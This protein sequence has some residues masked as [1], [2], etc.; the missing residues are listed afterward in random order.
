MKIK[1]VVSVGIFASVVLCCNATLY[2]FD[3]ASR[4]P[5]QIQVP[6]TPEN[7]GVFLGGHDTIT[8]EAMLLKKRAHSGDERF[9]TWADRESLPF[10]RVGAHDEDT[11]AVFNRWLNDPPL[12][13]YGWGNF[14]NH[15]YNPY[16]DENVEFNSLG[17]PATKAAQDYLDQIN[18]FTSCTPGGFEGLS[19]ADKN[20]LYHYLGRIMHLYQDM[21]CPSHTKSDIHVVK[22]P[23]ETY[24]D[25]NWGEITSSQA[26]RDRVSISNYFAGAYE[27]GA[28]IN[29]IEAMKQAAKTTSSYPAEEELYEW[30]LCSD[31]VSPCQV[32]NEERLRR[33]VE[34]LVPAA[35]LHSAGYIDSIYR[36]VRGMSS[37]DM[38]VPFLLHGPGGDHPDDR[39]DVSDAFY[40]EANLNLSDAA[41]TDLLLRT[42]MKKGNTSVWHRKQLVEM[43]GQGRA[44]PEDTPEGAKDALEKEFQRVLSRLKER[45][46]GK[47]WLT[48]PDVA[49]FAYGFYNPAISL[50]LKIKEPVRFLDLDFDPSIIR[51]HPVMLVPTAGFAGFEQSVSLKAKLEEYVRSGGTIIAFAQ[52]LGHHWNILP[53]P[54]NP[55]TG[56]TLPISGYGYQQDQNCQQNSVFIETYHPALSSFTSATIDVGVDGYFSSYPDNS[57]VLLRRTANGQPAMILYPYGNGYVVATTL[58]SDFAF[59]HNQANR[60]EINLIGNLISWAKKPSVL[61]QI[62][63]GETIALNIPV[64]NHMDGVAVSTKMEIYPP[65]RSALYAEQIIAG[66]V[67]S[68]ESTVIGTQ[69]AL[70]LN[71]ALGVYQVDYVLLDAQG[72]II[73]PSTEADSGRFILANPPKTG[74]PDKPIWFTITT[75]SQNVPFGEVFDY[76]FHVYNNSDVARNLVIKSIFGHTER[77]HTWNVSVQPRSKATVSG[78]DR[79]EDMAYMY[80]TMRAFLFDE[81]NREIGRYE[82]SFK[83]FFPFAT[84]AASSNKPVYSNNDDVFLK[85][86]ATSGQPGTY[87]IKTMILSPDNSLT[88]EDDRAVNIVPGTGVILDLQ[89]HLAANSNPGMYLV[90]SEIWQ[91]SRLL[92]S[93]VASFELP[94]SQIVVT[95]QEPLSFKAGNNTLNFG[96]RN[97]GRINIRSGTVDIQFLDPYGRTLYSGSHPFALMAGEASTLTVPIII[98]NLYFGD[99]MISYTQSDETKTGN[100]VSI[101]IPNSAEVGLLLDK[102]SYRI[103]YTANVCASI[104]NTGKFDLDNILATLDNYVIGF[105]NTKVFSLAR[106]QSVVIDFVMPIPETAPAG[107]HSTEFNLVIPSGGS[108]GQS[109]S[110]SIPGSSLA[111]HYNSSNAL[112]QGDS[113]PLSIE[114]TGGVDTTYRTERLSLTDNNGVT[115][116]SGTTN[117]TVRSGETKSFYEFQIPSQVP[118]GDAMLHVDVKDINTGKTFTFLRSLSLNGLEARIET[119]TDKDLYRKG[120][121]VT[122]ITN[123]INIGSLIENVNLDLSVYR[124]RAGVD[125]QFSHFLPRGWLPLSN[126]TG[127]ASDSEG[128]LYVVDPTEQLLI[129]INKN[130]GFINEFD[131][132]KSCSGGANDLCVPRGVAVG[133]DGSVY[134]IESG[135]TIYTSH[136]RVHKFDHDG[137]HRGTWGGYGLSE[138]NGLNRPSAIA[139]DRD[140]YVYIADTDNHRIVKYDSQG[141]FI[142]AWGN[143]GNSP[144]QFICPQGI[145]ADENGNIYVT[146]TEDPGYPSSG[147]HRVQKFDTSGRFIRQWGGY[148]AGNGLFIAPSGIAVGRDG[149]VYVGDTYSHTDNGHRIQKFDSSGVFIKAWGGQGRVEGTFE[150]PTGLLTD[151]DG[152]V[153]VADRGNSRIQKFNAEGDFVALWGGGGSTNGFFKGLRGLGVDVQGNIYVA[154]YYNERIQ[155]FDRNGNY[156]KQWGSEGIG[157]GQ[158]RSGPESVAVS[159]DG[160]VYAVNG[161]NSDVRIQK[162]D[163]EGNFLISWGSA[164]TGDGQFTGLQRIAV[165]A[166]GF[167]Y[168][169]DTGTKRVQKFGSDGSFITKWGGPGDGPGQFTE[170]LGIAISLD[171]SVY[172]A[173]PHRIQKF[174]EDGSFI[175]Q[176]GTQGSEAG[177]FDSIKA[178]MVDSKGFVYVIDS[179]PVRLQKFDSS[180]NFIT[181]WDDEGGG[182]MDSFHSPAGMVIDTEGFILISDKHTNRI[183]KLTP[184][185]T[186]EIFRRSSVISQPGNTNQQYLADLGA[187]SVSGKLYCEATLKNGIGQTLSKSLHPFYVASA[188][189]ALTM[190]VDKRIYKPGESITISGEVA[191]ISDSLLSGY[192]L[193]LILYSAS[194]GDEIFRNDFELSS[195]G[196][197]PFSFSFKASQEGAY[198][199]TAI[200]HNNSVKVVDVTEHFEVWAPK[201]ATEIACPSVVDDQPF[202]ID[203]IMQNTG[204]IEVAVDLTSSIDE[205]TFSMRIP[206]GTKRIV[207]FPQQINQDTAYRFTL[208]GDVNETHETWIYQGLIPSLYTYAYSMYQEGT[209]VLPIAIENSGLLDGKLIVS[210]EL[211]PSG[212]SFRK[213]YFIPQWGF[214]TDTLLFDLTEGDYTLTLSSSAPPASTSAS[215]SVRK[216]DAVTMSPLVISGPAGGIISVSSEVSNSGYRNTEGTAQLLLVN[217]QDV[218][219]WQSSQAINLPASAMATPVPVMFS[220]SPDAIQPGS[221]S[222]RMSFL[223]GGQ[224]ELAF[225]TVPLL[226]TGANLRLGRIPSYQTVSAGEEVTFSFGLTNLGGKT[227][228]AELTLKSHDFMNLTR[229]EMINPGEERNIQFAFPVPVDLEERDYYAEY[230]LKGENGII[231]KGQFRYHVTGINISV[232]A[233]L[234]KDHYREGETARLNMIINHQGGGGSKN[235]FARVNYPGYDD[236][237]PFSLGSSQNLSFDIPLAAISGEKL[238]Y[239]IYDE[240]G[241]SIHLNSLYIYK[242]GDSFSITTDKQVYGQ[243]EIV[244]MAIA[245]SGAGTMTVSGPG[246]YSETFLFNGSASKS[247]ALPQQAVAGTYFIEAS[248]IMAEGL[249][250]GLSKPIDIAGISVKVKEATLDKGKYLPG[251]NLRLSMRIE[252]NV[253]MPTTLKVW[254]VDPGK[255]TTLLGERPLSLSRV[256]QVQVSNEYQAAIASSGIHK[257]IYGI[258]SGYLLLSSGNL[259]FDAGDGVILDIATDRSDYPL[260]SEPV[261]VRINLYGTAA[262]AALVLNVN[263]VLAHT[264]AISFKGFTTTTIELPILGPGVHTLEGILTAGGLSS[265]KKTQLFYGSNL[266]DLSADVWGSGTTIAKDGTL[267]LLSVARN[268]GG[269]PASPTSMTLHD[270]NELLTA[271]TVRGLAPGAS[272]FFEFFWSVLG[273]AGERILVATLDPGNSTTEFIKDNNGVSRRIVIPDIALITE[274]D[275]DIYRA[276]EQVIVNATAI[277]L[278]VATNYSNLTCTTVIRDPSGTEI[279][280]HGRV[281]GASPSQIVLISATWNTAGLLTEGRYVIRQEI[282]SGSTLLAER[283]KNVTITAGSGLNLRAEPSSLRVKQGETGAF[284]ITVDAFA[285]WN[286]TIIF[287]VDGAPLGTTT[288]FLP[289]TM[290]SPGT[291]VLSITTD[292]A[293]V[294]G[295]Y[296]IVISAQSNDVP[297]MIVQTIPIT[298]EVSGFRLQAVPESISIAQQE[299]AEF[300]VSPLSLNGYEGSLILSDVSGTQAGLAVTV[301][302]T[303]LAVP[304]GETVVRVQSSKNALPG[305]YEINISGSDGV[306]SRNINL[307]LLVTENAAIQPGFV[308]TPGPGYDNRALVTLMNRNFEEKVEFIAFNTR[309][310]ANAVM[311]DIDGDGDDEII[312]APGPDPLADGRIRVFRKNGA[313]F[314]EQSIF[315]TKFGATLAAGDIDSD[316]REEIVVGAGPGLKNTSRLK[317]LSFDGQRFADTG[318]DFVAFPSTYKLGV[319]ITL[320]DVDGDGVLEIIAG[321]GPSPL[322]PPRIRVF[323]INTEGG[324]GRW[325]I[326]STLSDFVV[327]FGDWYPYLFGVNVAAGDVDGDGEDE[328]IA[329]AGPNPLQ[330]A[331]VAVYKGSGTF[332]GTRFEAYPANDYRFGVNVAARDLDGDG[333]AEIITGL[334]PS[335]FHESWVRVFRGDGT[336]LSDGFLAFPESMKSGVKVST[337]NVGE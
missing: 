139:V 119:R 262:E 87:N 261:A 302:N 115:I 7:A 326:A 85:V 228:F 46:F 179:N 254:S 67:P 107:L 331:V 68:H 44:L 242:T 264:E 140:G 269:T 311:G 290:S 232:V 245:G 183:R 195:S 92:S 218:V 304:G 280:R 53:T 312:V 301:V 97:N 123:I 332:T 237:R 336:L 189:I 109:T 294:P 31:N 94:R 235:L 126:P 165:N 161:A 60:S 206:P 188:N 201:L 66:Q 137:N 64:S 198:A 105:N 321:A 271:F 168:V 244:N 29:P 26:F 159:T 227:A 40:W 83:G 217:S 142:L 306:I 208:A 90:R 138:S 148:G 98:P 282:S 58:Y 257:I 178:I 223:D 158:F 214:T 121:T 277:N 247:F 57:I 19:Q 49:L 134:V 291:S 136:N 231:G 149:Y 295:T 203:V 297:A 240:E 327:N 225:Q 316:W 102:S 273:K 151:A 213:V 72:N 162:F 10:L 172:V 127:I 22:R 166:G 103:R 118:S 152:M 286:G 180:G 215:F 13:E 267:K 220:F 276:G 176:W 84:I 255:N 82:L 196:S 265:K 147:S 210:G 209:V 211:Q 230:E 3:N 243:G 73:Q 226:I 319:K 34:D 45:S 24:V 224:K 143:K 288:R 144:G 96:L 253:D 52:Q 130:G 76:T 4:N 251:D 8:S 171:G 174:N 205:R 157:D 248:L 62:R 81:S 78:S 324:I 252:S 191:N 310:G 289:E 20:R 292:G 5:A 86:M 16:T 181:Q 194:G 35:I 256:E 128:F 177:Q 234:D 202:S 6:Y 37:M 204:K 212:Y 17:R 175:T 125:S 334:G 173:E 216:K 275:K 32:L 308:L 88:F 279:Y 131:Y 41:L 284:A 36:A 266:P 145:A 233:S 241:R 199:L 50:M 38:C 61:P 283:T 329:G 100:L 190:S 222:A 95:F 75:T 330:K 281:F 133:Q 56:E 272:Q 337:G 132:N 43:F 65:G 110:I 33:N 333:K 27:I 93:V 14:F 170:P 236:R 71:G 28:S 42:A 229:R 323:K 307:P 2:G 163:S 79:F 155:K 156:L 153:Y 274:S 328:I 63:P 117:G 322:S 146:D 1:L 9:R 169:C 318:I 129:K 320:G 263:G 303:N 325:K 150:S 197:L 184:T 285:G 106:G 219:S 250:K 278:T 59:S 101:A 182:G 305:T 154:D 141:T 89:H 99:Y 54:V 55:A 18:T 70:P 299:T 309:F 287:D 23:Y 313:L 300:V 77:P 317:V 113:V 268:R 187:P 315:T 200:V 135:G 221:Y 259:S 80:D 185:G 167:V 69:L 260:G 120:E 25:K 335:P 108:L 246:G 186:E 116:L 47:D 15:F 21:F 298:L 114:N 124:L 104:N 258:Y 164:G 39:F 207:A 112:N 91:E 11:S 12:G 122:N 193:S 249:T 314:L 239:G 192:S 270:G 74:S 111:I 238:F 30:V 48:S 293:T 296:P 160:F 51:D